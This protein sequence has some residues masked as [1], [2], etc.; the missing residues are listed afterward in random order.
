MSEVYLMSH[1]IFLKKLDCTQ[2][3]QPDILCIH[4]QC[5]C[6]ANHSQ[7]FLDKDHI[8][9]EIDVSLTLSQ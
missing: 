1:Q 7:E 4:R 5:D 6:L 9:L 8:S 3:F 2:N